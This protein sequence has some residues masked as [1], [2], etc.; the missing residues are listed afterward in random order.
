MLLP[1]G[2]DRVARLPLDGGRPQ[3]LPADDP[4]S[5]WSASSSPDGSLTAFM[6]RGPWPWDLPEDPVAEPAR[7]QLV[8]VATDDTE[9]ARVIELEP[10]E[11]VDA[12]WERRPLWSP[13]GDRIAVVASSYSA[14][15]D[16]NLILESARLTVVDP[17]TGLAIT[18]GEVEDGG[19]LQPIAFSAD[20]E[21]ILVRR[22]DAEWASDLWS[23]NADGS[24]ST[25]LVAGAD[26]GEWVLP[27]RTGDAP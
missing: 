14:D 26:H 1:V 15:V 3:V 4:R 19:L 21:R 6:V 24:G 10:G 27:Y 5:H 12:G 13:R 7:A 16:G 9:P 2:G 23:M 22:F 8:I 18:A 20:G 17:T 25:M 11:Q